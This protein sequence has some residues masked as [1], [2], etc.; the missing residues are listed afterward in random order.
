MSNQ[1]N[2]KSKMRYGSALE[3][4]KAHRQDHQKWSRRSFLRNLG[5][6]GGASMILGNLPLT[7]LAASPLHHA[8]GNDQSDRVLVLIRL[9]GGNDGLNMIVPQFD[10]DY[11]AGLRPTLRIPENQLITLE[12]EL[13]MPNTMT[14]LRNLWDDGKMKVLSN[15]GYPD[16]NLSH[17][18]STDIW[19]SASDSDVVDTSGWLGRYLTG[20]HPDY[21]TNP[22]EKPPAIQ[23]GS[24]GSIVFNNA[25]NTSLAVNVSNP[26]E[27]FEIAANGRAYD[28]EN[29]P[30]CQYGEQLGYLRAVA[31]STY[32][33][34]GTIKEAYDASTTSVDYGQGQLRE[35]LAL[36]A[37]LIKGNLGT[38]MYMVNLGGFDTHANQ[39]SY[40]PA[41]MTE[42]AE[43]IDFFYQD[44]AA[45]DKDKHVLS[46]TFSEF[47]RRVQQNA[48][49]GT[50]HGSAA[51]VILFG[52][53][54]NGSGVMGTRPDLRN[55]DAAGNM[56]F[57][58][59]FR[60]VYATVLEDWLCIDPTVVDQ[61]LGSNFNRLALGI[62]CQATPVYNALR[63]QLEHQARYVQGGN[64]NIY[65][66]LPETMNI[67]LQI[68][69]MLGQPVAQLFKG[70]L[71]EGPHSYPF[72][73][74]GYVPNG[75]YV[76]RLEA[77]GQAFSRVIAF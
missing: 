70:R 52:E 31:N 23:I 14:A 42:L 60:E 76:Y 6:T 10:Y 9:S 61:T 13:A 5:L 4:G 54:L 7:A 30:E 64:I 77:D 15:V 72:Q 45:G 59:D 66:E 1:H 56:F 35:Q 47:G 40:H 29:L 41:L 57:D 38:K 37:R 62:S 32:I 8:L 21:L 63:L 27:L 3:H 43:A 25:E 67:D 75:H 18:R 12:D 20:L 39:P 19:S 58:I 53:G 22:P 33:Y 71:P 24:V 73:P 50:D 68:F 17:F 55:L 65:F 11:Y 44:L 26:E 74:K 36:V 49:N 48:S 46:M 2:N 28:V 34:A 69:N 51:P 16:Q